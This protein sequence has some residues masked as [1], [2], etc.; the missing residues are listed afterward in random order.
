[1]TDRRRVVAL[2][3]VGVV[4]VAAGAGSYVFV[5]DKRRDDRQAAVED[6]S[7]LELADP[8]G[9]PQRLS[10][11]RGKVLVVNFWATWCEPCREEVPALVRAQMTL[12][13]KGVQIVGIGIDSGPKILQFA[14]EYAINYPLAVAGV[15]IV[16]LTRRLG[17]RAGGLPYTLVLDRQ[18]RFA[19]THLGALTESTLNALVAPLTSS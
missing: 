6:L 4:A 1:M 17:N 8:S 10:Q 12:G 16:E 18:G 2:A 19:S 7:V 14:K 13:P 9:K 3:A 11:W 5:R 15:E